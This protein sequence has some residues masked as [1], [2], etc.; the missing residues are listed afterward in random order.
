M[1]MDLVSGVQLDK[2]TFLLLTMWELVW[3]GLALWR[4][5]RREEKYWYVAILVINSVGLLPIGYLLFTRKTE[6]KL[7]TKR[8]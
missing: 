3:K 2:N 4:A 6:N 5:A 8:K 1:I 7:R